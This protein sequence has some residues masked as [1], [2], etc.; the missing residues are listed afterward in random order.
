MGAAGEKR[1]RDCGSAEALPHAVR[2]RAHVLNITLARSL[3]GA[4]DEVEI[5][6]CRA[7]PGETIIAVLSVHLCTQNRV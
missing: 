3:P 7:V 4:E 6:T 1:R 5:T 2:K